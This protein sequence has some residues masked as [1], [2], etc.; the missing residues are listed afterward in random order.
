VACGKKSAKRDFTR[1]VAGTDGEVRVDET[2][3][4]AGRGAYLC[5]GEHISHQ[6]PQ[7]GRLEYALRRGITESEWAGLMT[8]LTKTI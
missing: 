8:G 6:Q 7:K 3:K 4:L 2:G 5:S 1:I